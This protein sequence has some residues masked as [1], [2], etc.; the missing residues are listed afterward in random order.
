M[1]YD[2]HVEES[3]LAD[4][5]RE[6]L[7]L[8]ENNSGQKTSFMWHKRGLLSIT[9]PPRWISL[10][11]YLINWITLTLVKTLSSRN[12]RVEKSRWI[13]VGRC[14]RWRHFCRSISSCPGSSADSWNAEISDWCCEWWDNRWSRG[15]CPRRRSHSAH[16][17]WWMSLL[18]WRDQS[19]WFRCFHRRTRTASRSP[20][21][22]G[23]RVG[24]S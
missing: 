14:C 2:L 1:N 19:C 13:R 20:S 15:Y 21:T 22:F 10:G 3:A 11:K 17:D 4:S 5:L 18:R 24:Q 7:D 8:L 12:L 9:T 6:M 23:S 16:Q